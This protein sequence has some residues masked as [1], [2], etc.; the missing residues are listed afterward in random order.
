M[1][2]TTGHPAPIDERGGCDAWLR[3]SAAGFAGTAFLLRS[4]EYLLDDRP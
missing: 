1:T 2:D 4:T 3:Q